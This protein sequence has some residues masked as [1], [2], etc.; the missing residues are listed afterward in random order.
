VSSAQNP[1]L[2]AF[3][4]VR[5][6]EGDSPKRSTSEQLTG[7]PQVRR[8]TRPV[9]TAEQHLSNTDPPADGGD[10]LDPGQE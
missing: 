5:T 6:F 8:R 7:S 2:S 10:P 4:R 1:D 3:G 9:T